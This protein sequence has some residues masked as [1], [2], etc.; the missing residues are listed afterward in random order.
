M[1]KGGCE[2][3]RK[4]EPKGGCKVGKKNKLVVKPVKKKIEEK[5]EPVVKKRLPTK[6][7][8]KPVQKKK[9]VK[10]MPTKLKIVEKPKAKKSNTD[11][12]LEARKRMGLKKQ[13]NHTN[14]VKR[15]ISKL[16][17]LE[18]YHNIDADYSSTTGGAKSFLNVKSLV[19][20]PT[21]DDIHNG[22]YEYGYGPHELLTMDEKSWRFMPRYGGGPRYIHYYS[23]KHSEWRGA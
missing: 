8:I 16:N 13:E 17:E 23:E 3:G 14:K 10:K 21:L 7:K 4:K 12:V 5:K 2:Q 9:M 18:A 19:G 20:N 15:L 1:N 22:N 6:L 11:I